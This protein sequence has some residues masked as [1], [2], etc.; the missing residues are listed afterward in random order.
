MSP[1]ILLTH[2]QLERLANALA[3]LDGL[4][5]KPGE[6]TPFHFNPETTFAIANNSVLVGEK[7][8]VYRRAKNLLMTSHQMGEQ[9]QVTPENV[10]RVK[11]FL[12]AMEELEDRKVEVDGLVTIP[13][14]KLAVGHDPKKNQNS[15][16]ASVLA[17][18]LP[19]LAEE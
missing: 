4:R 3:S 7:L 14:E 5:V 15:I 9:V 16:P 10:Q 18:L 6:F 13:R 19:I 1:P 11:E 12:T 17:G 8:T 2:A